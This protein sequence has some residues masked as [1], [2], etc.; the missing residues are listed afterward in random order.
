MEPRRP[1]LD[2]KTALEVATHYGVLQGEQ[3]VI[4]VVFLR[5]STLGEEDVLYALEAQQ[6]RAMAEEILER[7]QDF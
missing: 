7:I 3:G 6:A 4:P 5:F 1:P 2:P